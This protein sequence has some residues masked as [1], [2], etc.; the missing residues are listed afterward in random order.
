MFDHYVLAKSTRVREQ[1]DLP[2]G[3]LPVD[4]SKTSHDSPIRRALHAI[5]ITQRL[6]VTMGV[7]WNR[8]LGQD[9]SNK[10]ESVA[11][12]EA[13]LQCRAFRLG[14]KHDA[15][16]CYGDCFCARRVRGESGLVL[17]RAGIWC[18]SGHGCGCLVPW[19]VLHRGRA[20]GRYCLSG[21]GRVCFFKKVPVLVS[22]AARCR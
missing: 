12:L 16:P 13:D 21:A 20:V 22:S 7:R 9:T 1:E 5:A 11:R 4:M 8:V 15:T 17:Y 10:D 6:R 19:E 2:Q 18:C 3:G 14:I